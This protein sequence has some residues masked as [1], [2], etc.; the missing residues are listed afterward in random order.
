MVEH[1]L[2]V[3]ARNERDGFILDV[4][5]TFADKRVTAIMGPSGSGKTS[6]ARLIAGIDKPS[7]GSIRFR[8]TQ[9]VDSAT[10]LWVPAFKRSAGIVFQDTRLFAHLTVSDN[11]SF[12]EQRAFRA[13]ST[14][15]QSE[16][17][18]P[19]RQEIIETLRL[20]SLFERMPHTLSG[21]EA[22]RAA[23]ARSLLSRPEILVLD[24]PLSAVDRG[25]KPEILRLLRTL[26][27]TQGVPLL[28]VSHDLDE[29]SVVA[30][31]IAVMEKGAVSASGRAIDILNS[32]AVQDG[33]PRQDRSV[34]VNATIESH[35]ERLM[36]TSVSLGGARVQLPLLG[37]LAS[38]APIRVRIRAQDVA[39]SVAPPESLSIRN[40]LAGKICEIIEDEGT[41][42]VHV[43]IALDDCAIEA[44]IT[45]AAREILALRV[46]QAVFGLVKSANL[47]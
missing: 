46:G 17:L 29:V 39:I 35:D 20:S 16:R 1:G 38:G 25:A 23:L 15:R 27:H 9:W 26:T 47:V 3:R 6:L 31:E 21:G 28:Y 18:G 44:R 19:S 32:A 30:D 2:A 33:L 8:N 10:R 14:A 37:S 36:L 5:C 43:R 4:D 12:A 40:A 13:P 22:Q 7:V 34:V 41:P 11:L 45:R 24:E 42:F